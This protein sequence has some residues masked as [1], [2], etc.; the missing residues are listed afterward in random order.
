MRH[1]HDDEEVIFY[2]AIRCQIDLRKIDVFIVIHRTSL[3]IRSLNHA[4]DSFNSFCFSSAWPHV[5]HHAPCYTIRYVTPC[6]RKRAP[7]HTTMACGFVKKKIVGK[8]TRPHVTPCA[9]LHHATR[10]SSSG[11]TPDALVEESP[12]RRPRLGDSP[13]VR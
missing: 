8:N 2:G 1:L 12:R 11:K 9:M 3:Y 7:C 6:A 4:S 5:L 13:I 10:F